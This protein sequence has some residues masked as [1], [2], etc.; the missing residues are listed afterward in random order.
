MLGKE[1]YA[2]LCK[3]L[4]KALTPEQRKEVEAYEGNSDRTLGDEYIARI[5][6][7]LIDENGN[8]NEPTTWEK[9][10]AVVREFF[11]DAFGL[12]LTDADL[13]YMLWQSSIRLKKQA[14]Q[15]TAVHEAT[16]RRLQEST[17]YRTSE[18]ATRCLTWCRMIRLRLFS[19]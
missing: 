6:E 1:R 12:E 16:S 7:M 4:G 3:R 14:G 9:V 13:R 2:E 17:R 18:L 15:Y 10:K 19:L 11:R 8:I 5:A